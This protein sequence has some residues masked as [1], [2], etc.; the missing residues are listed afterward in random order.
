MVKA[1]DR[2]APVSRE[3]LIFRI[4]GYDHPRGVYFCDLEYAPEM[5]Y[6]S[7][8]R[9]ALRDGGRMKY[10]KFYF[11]EGLKFVKKRFPYYTVYSEIFQERMVGIRDE[12]IVELRKPD[13][14]LQQIFR[15]N[16]SDKLI[17]V[18]KT[19]IEEVLE[20]ST[21]KL[22]D[23][24]VFGSL[25]HDFYNVNYSDLDFIIYGIKQVEELREVLEELYRDSSSGFRNEYEGPKPPD[26]RYKRFHHLSLKEYMWHQKRK[27][28][29][30]VYNKAWRI[31]KI[32]FEPVKRW[33][34]I[35]NEY[36]NI[37]R[38]EKIGF[39]EAVVEVIDSSQSY[40]MPSVYRVEVLESNSIPSS[41]DVDR[42]VSYV[43]EFRLQLE[44]GEIGYVR[45][46]LEK[47]TTIDGKEEYQI[48]LTYGP[49]YFDQVLKVSDFKHV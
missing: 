13:E 14:K 5:L 19:V 3:G 48:T 45:G 30:S 10:Y 15:K 44:K 6:K 16:K 33:E 27:M 25:L 32:E 38:I 34:E 42:I 12:Q 4:L 7:S 26:S 28:I 40:F 20:I 8:D 29:Y 1:R 36:L 22:T 24:G 2:D 43:E 37:A 39:I 49:R 23:F 9:R 35:V 47:I 11:D 21:L 18:L 41:I 31:F 17:D 46:W